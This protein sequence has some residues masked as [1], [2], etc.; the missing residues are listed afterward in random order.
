MTARRPAPAGPSKPSRVSQN[1]PKSQSVSGAVW[2]HLERVPGVMADI[3]LGERQ[4]A[5]GKRVKL[6]ELRNRR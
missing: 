5:E 1:A 3:E 4:L 2:A 6:S